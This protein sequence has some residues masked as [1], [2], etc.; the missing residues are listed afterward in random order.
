MSI[1]NELCSE[2]INAVIT[3]QEDKGKIDP[4]EITRILLEVRQT[5]RRLR[6]DERRRSAETRGTHIKDVSN[7]PSSL[8]FH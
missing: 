8:Y 5:L 2:V 4:R 7:A 1:A 6:A 3:R